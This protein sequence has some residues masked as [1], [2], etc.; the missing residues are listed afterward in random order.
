M[1]N[2]VTK[3]VPRTPRGESS[4]QS[5]GNS[6]TEGMFPTQRPF[7][8]PVPVVVATFCSSD[9]PE[10]SFLARACAAF[11]AG[12]KSGMRREPGGGGDLGEVEGNTPGTGDAEG[13][14]KEEKGYLDM[15]I[16]MWAYDAWL[17]TSV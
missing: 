10:M 13:T 5:P 14:G 3:S 8:Y 16:V 1:G 12:P 9:Q 6:A 4:R 17:V 2:T 7:P 11:Q 15:G